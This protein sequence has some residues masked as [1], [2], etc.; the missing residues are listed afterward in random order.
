[1]RLAEIRWTG[2]GEGRD[3]SINYSGQKTQGKRR[4]VAEWSC[5][6]ATWRHVHAFKLLECM[7]NTPN[8]DL[9]ARSHW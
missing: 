7:D 3:G 5:N 1:M 8:K 2:K 4:H 6:P 9:K